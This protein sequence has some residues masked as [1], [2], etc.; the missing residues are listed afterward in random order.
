MLPSSEKF[1]GEFEDEGRTSP[2]DALLE[3]DGSVQQHGPRKNPRSHWVVLLIIHF[4][5]FV[6]NPLLFAIWTN[7]QWKGIWIQERTI[8]T[9]IAN[10]Y[11]S[12]L[13]NITFS[14]CR[15]SYQVRIAV[16]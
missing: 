7:Y 6:L 2:N 5:L 9:E 1:Y 13:L 8:C 14:T 3:Q 10:K 16:F 11:H 4:V 12:D 15:R